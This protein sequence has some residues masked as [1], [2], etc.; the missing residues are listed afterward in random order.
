MLIEKTSIA[1]LKNC[2]VHGFELTSVR[3][4]GY[5]ERDALSVT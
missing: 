5:T 2:F 1:S 4:P 3:Q